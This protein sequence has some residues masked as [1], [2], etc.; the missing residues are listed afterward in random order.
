M[1]INYKKCPNCGSKNSLRNIY[2]MPSHELFTEAKNGKVKLG[3]CCIIE[4][5]P[6][7]FC[8]D[9]ENEW[10]R[11]QSIDE[12]YG[13]IKAI[14]A[15]VGGYFGGYYNVE[16][17][18]KNLKVI[19]HHNGYGEE[20]EK[21]HKKIRTATATNFL[22]HLKM[23]DLLNWKSKYIELG[24]CDGTH[25]SVEIFTEG[26]TIIKHG[27]NMFPDEW[28]MFCKGIKRLTGKLFR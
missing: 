24:V 22:E 19:W 21:V 26:R 8:M 7:Y 12:A 6:E 11:S 25:W 18:F 5:G 28:N 27:D 16:V 1:A 15:S 13:K 23:I 3:G 2:G 4:D 17:D 9:C 14:K 10:N 20:E